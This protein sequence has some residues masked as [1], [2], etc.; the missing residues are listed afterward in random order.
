[1]SWDRKFE[2]RQKQIKHN[3]YKTITTHIE[4]N[5]FGSNLIKT[6]HGGK[7]CVL[8]CGSFVWS[9]KRYCQKITRKKC[10][11]SE[12]ASKLLPKYFPRHSSCWFCCREPTR[13]RL[14]QLHPHGVVHS[15]CGFGPRVTDS[16]LRSERNTR[17]TPENTARRQ[18]HLS[19]G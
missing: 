17:R 1:M 7:T 3:T 15:L 14:D 8:R 9:A 6:L 5:C 13:F 16:T 2:K 10:F 18:C 4:R 11:R 19:T 12:I